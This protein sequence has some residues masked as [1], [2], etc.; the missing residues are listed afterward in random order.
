MMFQLKRALKV[1][2][3]CY[4]ESEAS[5][6]EEKKLKALGQLSLYTRFRVLLDIVLYENLCKI[7][8]FRWML[9]F[10]RFFF[11]LLDVYPLLALWS[12][13]KKYAYVEIMKAKK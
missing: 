1:P 13:G 9:N 10:M 8:I 3:Y 11:A 5:D 2:G 4:F 12:F 7:F 6:N